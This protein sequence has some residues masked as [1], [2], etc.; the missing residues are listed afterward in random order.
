[1]TEIAMTDKPRRDWYSIFLSVTSLA[2]AVLVVLLVV[3][4][5]NFKRDNGE[6]RQQVGQLRQQLARGG[7]PALLAG[8]TLPSFELADA[9]GSPAHVPVGDGK[10]RLLLV[11]TSTCPHCAHA[12]PIWRDLMAGG[13][14]GVEVVGLQLDAG[15]ASAKPI[16]TLPFPV[17]SPGT[18]PPAF[19]ERLDGVPCSIVVDGSGKIETVIYG[20]PEGKD[21]EVLRV[22]L[23]GA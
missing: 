16:D 17:M 10:R 14:N 15:S 4:N 13:T 6:L 11:F 21:L 8:E 3:Q 18:S 7:R 23:H 9:S 22:A 20:P 19:L 2:L 1:M 5:R 12:M